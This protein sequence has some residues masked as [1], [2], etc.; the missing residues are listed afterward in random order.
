[1]GQLIVRN[2]DEWVVAALKAQAKA[3][4]RSA[5]AEHRRILEEAVAGTRRGAELARWKALAGDVRRR[6]RP[7]A[8]EGGDAISIVRGMRDGRP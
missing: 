3:N 8:G 4:G 5:E 1:M 7:A 6:S 2:L